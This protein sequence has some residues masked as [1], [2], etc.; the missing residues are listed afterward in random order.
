MLEVILNPNKYHEYVKTQTA[1]LRSGWCGGLVRADPSVCYKSV[2]L[3]SFDK[4]KQILKKQFSFF[5]GI[6]K[7]QDFQFY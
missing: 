1:S 2:T 5:G 7:L 4:S 6:K 3:N